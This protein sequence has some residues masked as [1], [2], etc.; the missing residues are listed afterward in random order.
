MYRTGDLARWRA[1]GTLEFLGR[2]DQQVK[3][4]GFRIELGEIEAALSAQPAVAQAAVMAREDGPGGKQLVAYV[5]AAPGEMPEVAALRRSLSERLP[6]YMVPSGFV[7]LESL[8]LTA[9]GKLDRRALPPWSPGVGSQ[10]QQFVRPR[11]RLEHELAQIWERILGV[12]P[13]S[14]LD[15]FFEL[16]GNSLLA[17]RLVSEINKT[18]HCDL[19]VL[20]LF[21]QPTIE[22]LAKILPLGSPGKDL[23]AL[24]SLRSGGA[25]LPLFFVAA[26]GWQFNLAGLLGDRHPI[27]AIDVPFSPQVLRAAAAGDIASLPTIE[28]TAAKEAALIRSQRALWSLPSGRVLLWRRGGL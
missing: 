6:D 20:T 7:M 13:V 24:F 9:N 8:P 26:D 3:I 27:F 5:V 22:Q 15:S 10:D 28:E 2:A 19:R 4:R 18:L 14:V 1:D 23:P 21:Q 12:Q 11:T 17:V 25:G 16:G